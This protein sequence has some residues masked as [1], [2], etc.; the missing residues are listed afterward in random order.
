MN[1]TILRFRNYVTMLFS[2]II[3]VYAD[4]RPWFSKFGTIEESARYSELFSNEIEGTLKWT[5][6]ST[7]YDDL[8]G[9]YRSQA[10]LKVLEIGIQHGGSQRILKEYFHDSATIMGIDIDTNCLKCRN[11]YFASNWLV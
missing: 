6:Y 5:H 8:L 2:K 4:A 10:N 9:K 1:R 11:W 3:F 7:V